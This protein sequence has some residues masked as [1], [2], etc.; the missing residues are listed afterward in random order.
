MFNSSCLW[1]RTPA[2]H[3]HRLVR[4]RTPGGRRD[5]PSGVIQNKLKL[6]RASC[7]WSLQTKSRCSTGIRWSGWFSASFVMM[8]VSVHAFGIPPSRREAATRRDRCRLPSLGLSV[9]RTRRRCVA[10]TS[11]CSPRLGATPLGGSGAQL[12][13][14]EEELAPRFFRG[15]AAHFISVGCSPGGSVLGGRRSPRSP[16][17]LN[18]ELQKGL[19][20]Y[21]LEVL[22]L[23]GH[24]KPCEL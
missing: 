13:T 15:L 1:C 16:G 20:V 19:R 5:P 11:S 18:S 22:G 3:S 24:P 21:G 2:W 8:E 14:A 4:C 7:S 6:P 17:H 12:A 9:A 10:P 23:G